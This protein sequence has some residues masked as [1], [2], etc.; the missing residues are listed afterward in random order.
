MGGAENIG[1]LKRTVP[2]FISCYPDILK[3]VPFG[4]IYVSKKYIWTNL[5]VASYDKMPNLYLIISPLR[6][7][8]KKYCK[9]YKIVGNKNS[10]HWDLKSII[11]S[12]MRHIN[13]LTSHA[14]VFSFAE[15]FYLLLRYWIIISEKWWWQKEIIWNFKIVAD[16]PQSG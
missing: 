2:L 14:T 4:R 8:Q 16:H 12:G 5:Q 9:H 3:Y 13:P 10:L 7:I 11:G 6:R 15:F 1:H